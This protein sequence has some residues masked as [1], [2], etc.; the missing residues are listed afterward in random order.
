MREKN[1]LDC[2]R[3]LTPEIDDHKKVDIS[4][5]FYKGYSVLRYSMEVRTN[6]DIIET[7][8]NKKFCSKDLITI[9]DPV[10]LFTRYYYNLEFM[11]TYFG[12]SIELS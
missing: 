8:M 10:S 3:L 5:L 4:N 11:D 12:K 6:I 7:I 2:V 1:S 9:R